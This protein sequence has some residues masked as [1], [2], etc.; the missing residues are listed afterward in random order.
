MFVVDNLSRP[1]SLVS[2]LKSCYFNN[3]RVTGPNSLHDISGRLFTV[4]A[5]N[6]VT[7]GDEFVVN[8]HTT[9]DQMGVQLTVLNDKKTV[10]CTW[11]TNAYAG[12]DT[13]SYAIAARI[14]VNFCVCVYV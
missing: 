3:E 12:V 9:N 14:L 2:I 11:Y 5:A 4:D 7:F 6:Q 8:E 13:S 1:V 10:V